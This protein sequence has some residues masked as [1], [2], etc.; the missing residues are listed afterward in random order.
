MYREANRI[1]FA[2]LDTLLKKSYSSTTHVGRAEAFQVGGL[3]T[4]TCSKAQG[5]ASAVFQSAPDPSPAPPGEG[6][7]LLLILQREEKSLT[8]TKILPH[9]RS[10]LTPPNK[11][12]QLVKREGAL[13]HGGLPR[14]SSEK[15]AILYLA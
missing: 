4:S 12:L 8:V 7:K 6:Q 14:C 10:D 2:S 1:P 15:D 9:G 11:K 13:Q 5:C 3:I